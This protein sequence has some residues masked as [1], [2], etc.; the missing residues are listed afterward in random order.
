M[1]IGLSFVLMTLVGTGL[2]FLWGVLGDRVGYKRVLV[3]VDL[4]FAVSCLMLAT[5]TSLVP[6]MVA[7]MLGGY[8]GQGGGGLRGSFGPGPRRNRRE[9]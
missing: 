8:G 6:I 9:A 2:V 3:A 5:S 1:T 4:L 7:A